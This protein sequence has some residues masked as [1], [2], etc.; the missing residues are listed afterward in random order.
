MRISNQADTNCKLQVTIYYLL[1]ELRL[2]FYIKVTSRYLLHE[3]P[4]NF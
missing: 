4:V 2:T 1:H 3:L